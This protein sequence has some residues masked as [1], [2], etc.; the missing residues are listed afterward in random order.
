MDT[1]IL[2][3]LGV[4]LVLTAAVFVRLMSVR[5]IMPIC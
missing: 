2:I 4:L 3:L 5:E 1:V